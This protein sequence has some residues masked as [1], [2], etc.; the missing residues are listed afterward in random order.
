MIFYWEVGLPFLV[1]TD[2]IELTLYINLEEGLAFIVII[3]LVKYAQSSSI[4]Y[5]I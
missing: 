1:M 2:L 5:P 3:D 4:V